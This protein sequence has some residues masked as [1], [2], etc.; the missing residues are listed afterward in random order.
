MWYVADNTKGNVT[1][2]TPHLV[3]GNGRR[4]RIAGDGRLDDGFPGGHDAGVEVHLGFEAQ[5]VV[6]CRQVLFAVD[7]VAYPVV[8]EPEAP[9]SKLSTVVCLQARNGQFV[10][11]HVCHDTRPLRA[12]KPLA[13]AIHSCTNVHWQ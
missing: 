2:S 10:M 13:S 4:R 12:G 11:G 9:N 6:E 7:D 1:S 3:A 8:R 5:N